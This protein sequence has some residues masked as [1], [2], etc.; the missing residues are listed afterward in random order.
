M[1]RIQLRRDTLANFNDLVPVEG[2]PVYI[3]DTDDFKIGDGVLTVPNLPSFGFSIFP[4]P[5]P[6]ADPSTGD[7]W[8][9]TTLN[10]FLVFDGTDWVPI[11]PTDLGIGNRN[12]NTLDITNNIGNDAT[13]PA[14]TATLAGLLTAAR[15]AIIDNIVIPLNFIDT[16]D[17]TDNSTIP[18]LTDPPRGAG[19]AWINI[20]GTI[21]TPAAITPEWQ[22][23][24]VQ[25]NPGPTTCRPGDV[26][27]TNGGT[28]ATRTLSYIPRFVDTDIDTNTTYEIGAGVNGANVNLNLVGTATDGTVTTD[29]ITVEAGNNI[30]FSN[31]GAGQFAINSTGGGGGGG[32]SVTI[33]DT[34]PANA[35]EGDLFWDTDD[36]NGYVFAPNEDGDLTWVPFTATTDGSRFQV[37]VQATPPAVRAQGDL[38]WDTDDGRMYIFVTDA[39]IVPGGPAWIPASP[40]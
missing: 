21:D 17:F 27:Y 22:A 35:T 14:A 19:D 15:A 8:W 7:T 4:G 2:E 9:N 33:G 6:P 29:T 16:V 30:T 11:G 1:T 34:P 31:V 5:N 20:A 24:I 26:V 40:L 39:A 37:P 10:Q 36:G 3:T 23:L 28:P 13:I 25:P 18:V 38:F 32:A 12:A